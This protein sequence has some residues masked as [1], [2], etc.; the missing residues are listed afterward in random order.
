MSNLCNSSAVLIFLVI[1]NKIINIIQIVAPILAIIALARLLLRLVLN[2]E[3]KKAKKQIFNSLLALVLVFLVPFLVKISVNAV[4]ESYLTAYCFEE[5]ELSGIMESIFDDPKYIEIDDG[6]KAKPVI[7]NPDDYEKGVPEETGPLP[8]GIVGPS[9]G[10]VIYFLNTGWSSDSIIIQDGD[11]FGLIDTSLST[12]GSFIVKQLKALNVKQLDFILLTHMHGDHIGGYRKIM[13]N[14]PVRTLIIK[15]D[16]TS[17]STHGNVYKN[18]INLAKKKGAYICN[19]KSSEC[20]NFTLGNISFN[21]YNTDYIKFKG[22]A[23]QRNKFENANSLCAV[24]TINGRR[25]YFSGDIGNYYGYDRENIVDAQVGDVDVYKVAHHGY[26]SFNNHLEAV[27]KLQAEYA[28]VTN[29]KVPA[30]VAIS[31]IKRSNS[32][33]KKT[34]YTPNGTVMLMVDVDG[35]MTFQQ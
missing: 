6:K 11:R 31:R 26:V 8:G 4:S 35:N 32:K 19:A 29:G 5:E 20:K 10:N 2:P 28:V 24:A 25:I 3:D 17:D 9:D 34:Y 15:A 33:F 21:L 23:N 1:F 27:N 7:P 30:S 18:V 22:T 14:F 16:G 13:E 12:K